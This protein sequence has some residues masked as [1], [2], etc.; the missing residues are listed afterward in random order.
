MRK[1]ALGKTGLFVSEMG[2]GTWGLAGEA[3]GPVEPTDAERVIHRAIDVG[4]TLIDTADSY[5]GG[6]MEHLLGKALKSLGSYK[7]RDLVVVTKGG[8][9]RSTI[10]PRKRFDR[11]YLV[12]SVERS[13]KRLGRERLDV[14]LLHNPSVECLL[15]GEALDTLVTLKRDGKIGHIGVSAGE[16]EA[17]MTALDRGAEVISMSYN[18]VHSADL[19]R[20]A[21]E[22]MVYGAGVLAHSPL[23]YGLLS[24]AWTQDRT[25]LPGDHRERR[26]EKHEL[27]R[28]VAQLDAMRFLVK[29]NVRSLRAAAIRFVLAN[30]LVSCAIL[31]PRTV[32]QLVEL[33][34][35][36]G[37]GP[38]YLPDAD[39]AVLPRTLAK[40][41]IMM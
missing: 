12:D 38:I 6:H 10:P 32:D 4:I 36:T 28:R 1:R 11:A 18:L 13:L 40:V 31:G 25:F 17:A 5:G 29:G 30:H 16:S 20:V 21:G 35:E 27:A 14:Y 2:I 24:D 7:S 39:M 8:T 34:R 33:V 23:A 19:H 3:Y 26:W 9:D 15:A 37:G 22:I 41:G